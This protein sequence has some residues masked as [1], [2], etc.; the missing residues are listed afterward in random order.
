MEDKKILIVGGGDLGFELVLNILENVPDASIT[1]VCKELDGRI[2]EL[3]QVYTHLSV[4][5]KAFQKSD[6]EGIDMVFIASKD[7]I[8]IAVFAK[9][10]MG[11]DF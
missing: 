5:Q 6:L 4:S 10:N 3:Q 9:H 7:E 11:N 8:L 1:I 2:D